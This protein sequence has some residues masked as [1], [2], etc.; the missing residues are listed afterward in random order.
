MNRHDR[1]D[2]SRMMG[3]SLVDKLTTSLSAVHGAA[4]TVCCVRSMLG[5]IRACNALAY[6]QRFLATLV[7][8][9]R[10]RYQ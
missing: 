1:Y 3:Q 4:H 8:T 5:V 2:M 10:Y 9:G 6:C 7:F